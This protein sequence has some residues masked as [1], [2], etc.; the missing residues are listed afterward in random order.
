MRQF[1]VLGTRRLEIFSSLKI[2]IVVVVVVIVVVV[3][4]SAIAVVFVSV[5][6]GFEPTAD[7]DRNGEPKE[8]DADAVV[9]S[10]GCEPLNKSAGDRDSV[11]GHFSGNEG[12]SVQV[13]ELREDGGSGD[14]AGEDHG[15]SGLLEMQDQV[16]L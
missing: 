8:G 4:V 3:A 13:P 6:R 15:A 5:V 9:V 12:R 7:S 16:L 11:F 10:G 14:R 2:V 1:L